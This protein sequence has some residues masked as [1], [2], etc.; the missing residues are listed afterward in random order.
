MTRAT[1]DRTH[2]ARRKRAE[3]GLPID[4]SDPA[5]LAGY[6]SLKPT[7]AKPQ[8]TSGKEPPSNPF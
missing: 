4:V 3:Q 7:P 5:L 8:T 2:E 1:K 6:R